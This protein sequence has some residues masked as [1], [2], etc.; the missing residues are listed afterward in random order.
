AGLATPLDVN[1]AEAQVL[2][3]RQRLVAV[4]AAVAKQKIDLPRMVGFAPTDQ[5]DLA[6]DTASAAARGGG[7]ETAISPARARPRPPPAAP[8]GRPRRR[9]CAR[10]S[11]RSRR[12]APRGFRRCR[13]PPTT[14]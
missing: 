5:H 12:F 8:V 13:S 3:E 10:P 9:G 6:A 2:T 7:A 1:R 14:G 4:Q 11:G